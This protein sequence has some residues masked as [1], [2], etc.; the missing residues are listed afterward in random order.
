MQDRWLVS[1]LDSF[2]PQWQ[3]RASRTPACSPG[4]AEPPGC[5]Q[6][7][8]GSAHRAGTA[9]EKGNTWECAFHSSLEKEAFKY[10][11][12]MIWILLFQKKK[13]MAMVLIEYSVKF[14]KKFEITCKQQIC[15]HSLSNSLTWIDVRMD[16]TS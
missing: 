7:C 2:A 9:K 15:T 6:D 3:K 1:S 13:I 16:D 10:V 4:T 8:W 11:K 5:W 12:K 14:Y